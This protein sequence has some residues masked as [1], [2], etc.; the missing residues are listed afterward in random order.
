MV[1]IVN[2]NLNKLKEK[3]V[4][5]IIQGKF[6][7]RKLFCKY[8]SFTSSIHIFRNDILKKNLLGFIFLI[9]FKKVCS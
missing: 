7:Q 4:Y 1:V 9:L 2:I 3:S 6:G 8:K 5:D